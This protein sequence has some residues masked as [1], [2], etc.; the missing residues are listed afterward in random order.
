MDSFS[1]PFPQSATSRSS[2]NLQMKFRNSALNTQPNT[3]LNKVHPEELSSGSMSASRVI[4]KLLAI[5]LCWSISRGIGSHQWRNMQACKNTTVKETCKYINSQENT[6]KEDV[7]YS[8]IECVHNRICR[9]EFKLTY[10]IHPPY[11]M[12]HTDGTN[13]H[14]LWNGINDMLRKC[15]GNC[16]QYHEKHILQNMSV[17]SAK[18]VDESDI[19][20][21][22][23]ASSTTENLY[24]FHFMPYSSPSTF[25][26]VTKPKYSLFKSIFVNI[27]PGIVIL[28]L[29]SVVSGFIIWMLEND[30]QFN[31][32]FFRGWM[33]GIW[34]SFISI[35][36]IGYGDIVPISFS[37]RIF[38]VI[39][40]SIG[41]VGFGLLT[42]GLTVEMM[43]ANKPA[44]RSIEGK[45]VG[46]LKN[47]R[48]DSFVITY[49]GGFVTRNDGIDDFDSDIT[50]LMQKVQNHTIDG[51][52]IDLYTLTYVY[53]MAEQIFDS[54]ELDSY[55][56][57]ILLTKIVYN[58]PEIS[59]GV[60]VKDTDDFEYFRHFSK[61]YNVVWEMETTE[62]WMNELQTTE[63]GRLQYTSG[64]EFLL[65][66]P[67][68]KYF[69]HTVIVGGCIVIL[70]F[71]CGLICEMK[72]RWGTYGPRGA[73]C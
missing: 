45:H 63:R 12:L 68:K 72:A 6:L 53:R 70:I 3:L 40:I 18:A 27:L 50:A 39:W 54:D 46:V 44:P 43:K 16:I 52:V 9:K 7:D 10:I 57:N 42:G 8:K 64:I 73:Q 25:I 38:S 14:P 66:S 4:M 17:L 48:I 5:V 13:G 37:G 62:W 69:Q 67:T 24:G 56:H 55:F 51:F 49:N 59:Y 2:F 32:S 22:V 26:F 11:Y 65:F 31:P 20:Y 35:T 41:M 1:V 28:L 29:L 60:L 34:W 33:E 71:M 30:N 61:D 23:L 15:C 19:V 58:G 36:T 21:P 47:R